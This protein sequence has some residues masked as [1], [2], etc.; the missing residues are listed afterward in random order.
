MGCVDAHGEVGQGPG[1][2]WRPSRLES[3]GIGLLRID[4]AIGSPDLA[5]VSVV[6]HCGRTGDH[7]L[8]EAWSSLQAVGAPAD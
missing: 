2:T 5:P 3:L 6:E 4:L 1:W 7:C 8:L